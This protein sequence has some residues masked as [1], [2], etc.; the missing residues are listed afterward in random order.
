MFL[1]SVI[2]PDLPIATRFAGLIF[3]PL[4]FMMMVFVLIGV[5]PITMDDNAISYVC[6]L[7]Y[8]R[9]RWDEI[10]RVEADEQQG[11]LVFHGNRKHLAIPGPFGWS[12]LEKEVMREFMKSQIMNRGIPLKWT[13]RAGYYCYWSRRTRSTAH[14]TV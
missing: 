8:Y 2:A 14:S 12:G 13:R 11:S 5:G 7:G 10:T 6:W 1:L 9:I 3:F 4:F